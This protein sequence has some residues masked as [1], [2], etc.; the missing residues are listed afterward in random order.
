MS[1]CF[2]NRHP[3]ILPLLL[4]YMFYS[5]FFPQVKIGVIC[6]AEL[7]RICE[8]GLLLLAITIPEMEVNYKS[9]TIGFHLTICTQHGMFISRR[10][11]K[12]H[13]SYF[14]FY[15]FSDFLAVWCHLF[16]LKLMCCTACPL[17][18]YVEDDNSTEVHWCSCYSKCICL[19]ELEG[20]N[21]DIPLQIRFW[22]FNF[23]KYGNW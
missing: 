19:S 21:V 4:V 12:L 10:L 23:L 16:Y 22:T 9:S 1:Y 14:Y 8:K 20:P 2:Q 6:P 3:I 5:S 15:F 7:R 11:S 17:A 13:H 18:F